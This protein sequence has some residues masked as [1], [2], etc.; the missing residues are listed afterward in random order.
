MAAV[1]A[2]QAGFD[3]KWVQ[4]TDPQA[5][6]RN[7][8]GTDEIK[9]SYICPV[10]GMKEL[11]YDAGQL[12]GLKQ[13]CLKRRDLS[14]LATIVYRLGLLLQRGLDWNKGKKYFYISDKNSR[15]ANWDLIKEETPVEIA[16][17]DQSLSGIKIGVR[18]SPLHEEEFEIQVQDS[19]R[20]IPSSA[21]S[22]V[23]ISPFPAEPSGLYQA[24]INDLRRRL[25]GFVWPVLDH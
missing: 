18:R 23:R 6:A 25:E 19:L 1:A 14:T 17:W 2:P 8:L 20:Y 5:A 22:H 21:I 15:R 4:C 11:A 3:F 16:F 9:V 24:H 13:D 12:Y 10:S 7:F